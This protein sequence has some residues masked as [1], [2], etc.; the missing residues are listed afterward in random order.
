MELLIDDVEVDGATKHQLPFSHYMKPM[1]SRFVIHR[2][3]AMS[4]NSKVNI[5]V[6]D[7]I[8][9]MKRISPHGSKEERKDHVQYYMYRLQ[10]SGYAK[11]ERIK[12]YRKAKKRFAEMIRNVR[13]GHD[14]IYRSKFWHLDKRNKEK[15][16]NQKTWF[17][18]KRFWST[19]FVNTK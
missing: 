16:H 4:F 7:L 15:E 12:V 3:S 14:S 2:N 19:S 17:K 5:L 13:T 1:S 9:I 8:H 18:R 6:N 11:E 10:F